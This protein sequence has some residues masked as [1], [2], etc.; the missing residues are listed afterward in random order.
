MVLATD[1]IGAVSS[2]CYLVLPQSQAQ[3]L[4]DVCAK[5]M[6]ITGMDKMD[7]LKEIDNIIVASVITCV[8]NRTK[9]KIYGGTPQ[10][11]EVSNEN[12]FDVI[13]KEIHALDFDVSDFDYY[14][15]AKT[16][17]LLPQYP[18][19]KPMFLWVYPEEFISKVK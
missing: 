12:L 5:S 17:F 10:A 16:Q 11:L 6:G 9:L 1:I 19:I 18:S 15:C 8:A 7:I 2:K 3:L 13:D 14:I 4:A